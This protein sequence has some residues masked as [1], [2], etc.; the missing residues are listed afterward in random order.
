M[1]CHKVTKTQR[2]KSIAIL[3]KKKLWKQKKLKLGKKATPGCWWP[4]LFTS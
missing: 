3:A 1:Y 4:M 2:N